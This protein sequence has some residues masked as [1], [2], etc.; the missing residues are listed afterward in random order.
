MAGD[1]A[2]V[3]APDTGDPATEVAPRAHPPRGGAE[4]GDQLRRR[5]HHGAAGPRGRARL[6][7]GRHPQ[8]RGAA[9]PGLRA[10]DPTHA[11]SGRSRRRLPACRAAQARRHP[12]AAP[13]RISRAASG[14][15]PLHPVLRSLPALAPAPRPVDAP[16]PSRRREVLR[17]LRRPEAED[18]RT[19]H[20]RGDRGRALRRRAR[21]LARLRHETLFSLATLNARIAELLADLNARPMR[22]YRA[23]RREL[24]ERLD[25]PALR[26]LPAEAFV[27]SDWKVGARV[28]LDYHIELHG[29]YYSVPYALIHEHVDARLTATTVEIFHRGQRVAAHRR[30]TVRGTHTTDPAHMP[31]AHQRP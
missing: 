17:R 8:R 23:S 12:R 4:P 11:S 14:R 31:K 27:Y 20:R 22:L 13:S 26:P 15:L 7:S 18:H 19:H 24:F 28:S 2:T 21:R 1:R 3:H 9:G 29:H 30:S 5:R 16:G 10:P 6:G 25:Q